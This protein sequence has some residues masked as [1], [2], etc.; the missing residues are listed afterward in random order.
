M[1]M[2]AVRDQGSHSCRHV[3]LLTEKLFI[4]K[5]LMD[6]RVTIT[7]VGIQRIDNV[8]Q[9]PIRIISS[10]RCVR[11]GDEYHAVFKEVLENSGQSVL[12]KLVIKK[13]RLEVT[14]S[15][16]ISVRMVFVP[17]ER[18]ELFYGAG[19]GDIRLFA[20]TASAARTVE[21]NILRFMVEYS[22]E[23]EGILISENTMEITIDGI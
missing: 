7:Q 18:T 1:S 22:L 6:K 5:L 21:G 16:A 20:G 19:G 14:K 11:L 4:E 9:E 23:S 13:D 12:T 10:G 17:G 8:L 2:P 3:W 15:G